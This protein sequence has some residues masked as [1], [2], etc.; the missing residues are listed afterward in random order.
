VNTRL[1]RGAYT[2]SFVDM[3]QPSLP[4]SRHKISNYLRKIMSG[5]GIFDSPGSGCSAAATA[6]LLKGVALDDLLN[7]GIWRSATT[8]AKFDYRP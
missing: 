8:V 5:L 7:L 2:V 1:S 3:K 4:L 6:A